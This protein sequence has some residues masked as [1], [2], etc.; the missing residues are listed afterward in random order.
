MNKVRL[1]WVAT[2][3]PDPA[4][5]GAKRATNVLV[6]Y[7]FQPEDVYLGLTED[8][9]QGWNYLGQ[10]WAIKRDIPKLKK[11][12]YLLL[13][14]IKNPFL[15]LSYLLYYQYQAQ[16]P[17]RFQQTECRYLV[18]DGLHSWAMLS[19]NFNIKA[20][21][22]IYRS[23]NVEA[24][25]WYQ[26]FIKEGHWVKKIIFYFE[27]QLMRRIEC[28]LINVADVTLTVSAQDQSDYL[29][30]CPQAHIEVL[31]IGFEFNPLKLNQT[32]SQDSVSQ[33]NL[34]FV[35]RLDWYPNQEGLT[36]FLN[37]V[38]PQ[39]KAERSHLVI[40]GSGV[41]DYLKPFLQ[42]FKNLTFYSNLPTLEAVYEACDLT[43]IPLFTGSGTRVKAIESASFSRSFL[44][45]ELGVEGLG[46]NPQAHYV[47]LSE[48]ATD[49]VQAINQ[50]TPQQCQMRAQNLYEYMS[51]LY[52][53]KFL[54]TQAQKLMEVRL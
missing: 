5:T 53:A 36:W 3:W 4:N 26:R 18:I 38:W 6:K 46:L 1:L 12:L 52:S 16:V 13:R 28:R 44:S 37:Q 30:F 9:E 25:I 35:G 45:T 48:Q 15:P 42:K 23:H 31:P 54:A 34:L 40:V 19:R 51:H 32:H 2:R 50:I 43:I 17:H 41:A 14:K 8:N 21:K 49:W 20:Q 47:S 11:Y 27:Y 24:N 33:L 22:L 39:I 7:L 29:K 10:G